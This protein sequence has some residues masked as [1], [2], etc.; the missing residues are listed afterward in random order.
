MVGAGAATTLEGRI[1]L[2]LRIFLCL[3]I[4]SFSFLANAQNPTGTVM[5]RSGAGQL[6]STGWTDAKSTEG[7]FSVRLPVPFDDFTVKN[8]DEGLQAGR[9]FVIGAATPEGVKL[10]VIRASY[11]NPN[12]AEHYFKNWQKGGVLRGKQEDHRVTNYRDFDA[13]EISA[14]DDSSIV[15]AR[16]ILV[17]RDLLLQTIESPLSQRA[18]AEQLKA[19]FFQS[20]SFEP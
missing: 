8:S 16:T 2:I 6:D 20:L 7:K 13:I 19:T 14:S 17:K 18:V 11:D 4:L 15:Y 9:F 10:S 12:A 5:H 1:K 3:V